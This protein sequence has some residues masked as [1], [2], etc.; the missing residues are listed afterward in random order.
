MVFQFTLVKQSS[1][2]LDEQFLVYKV[3]YIQKIM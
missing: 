1:P 2:Y 3:V